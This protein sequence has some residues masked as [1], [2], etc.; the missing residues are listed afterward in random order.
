MKRP[1]EIIIKIDNKEIL[2]TNEQQKLLD[3]VKELEIYKFKFN[4]MSE[5]MDGVNF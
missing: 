2:T 3:Y 5:I 4:Q 1:N